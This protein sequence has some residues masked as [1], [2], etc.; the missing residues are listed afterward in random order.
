[1]MLFL[2]PLFL[3]CGSQSIDIAEDCDVRIDE[4]APS[5]A[6]AGD[7]ISATLR[8]TTTIWDTAVYVDDERAE[9]VE[10]IRENCETCDQCKIDFGCLD[11]DDCDDC[12]LVCRTECVE[13]TTFILPEISPGEAQVVIYNGHGGSNP[14]PLLVTA[15]IDTGDMSDD[16]G[17]S[18]SGEPVDS[19]AFKPTSIAPT[20]GNA[21][22]VIHKE[23]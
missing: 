11:C 5:E 19:S 13:S 4:I 8:P 23:P 3:S 21:A 7:T 16:S 17:V 14:Y 12:D 1:M 18:D 6:Q 9:V 2:V 22:R 20:S 10:I 15:N